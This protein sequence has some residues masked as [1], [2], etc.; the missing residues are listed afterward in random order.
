MENNIKYTL[1]IA[2]IN[3]EIAKA[4]IELANDQNNLKVKENLLSLLQD[5]ETVY[6]GSS[7]DLEKLFKKYGVNK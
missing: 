6:N 4:N 3:E 5:K 1:V 2:K 7:N